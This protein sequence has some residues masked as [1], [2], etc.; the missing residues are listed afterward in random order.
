M[1]CM[2]LIIFIKMQSLPLRPISSST[3]PTPPFSSSTKKGQKKIKKQKFS[4]ILAATVQAHMKSDLSL[5][6]LWATLINQALSAVV[7]ML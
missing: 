7:I 4:F 1:G 5:K 3:V 6:T 2:Q